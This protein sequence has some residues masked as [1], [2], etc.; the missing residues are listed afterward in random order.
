M[1]EK[2]IR[3]WAGRAQLIGDTISAL[4]VARHFKKSFPDSHLIWPIAKKCSQAAPL[5]INCEWIDEIYVTDGLDGPQSERDI[6]KRHSCDIGINENPQHPFGEQWFNERCIYE[7]TWLMAGRSKAIWDRLTEEEKTPK[8][9]KWFNLPD[10][11][12]QNKTIGL[13]CQAGYAQGDTSKR[14][15]SKKYWEQ[16][17]LRLVKE[18]YNIL[19][20][21]SEKDWNYDY[22]NLSPTIFK[23]LNNLSFFDQIKYSLTTDLT[24]GTDSGS[25]LVLAAYEHPQIS[26]LR[27]Y[28][29][30]GHIQ[31]PM[32][33]GPRNKNN[34]SLASLTESHDSID[35][36]LIF[37]KIYEFTK[38]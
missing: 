34:F 37:N 23:R 24:I 13:W 33:F 29:E 18:G 16:V 31:N 21:G 30:D 27:M 38:R 1:S 5:Y 19:Q 6:K 2:H 35:Q 15:P 3:I 32:A 20:F 22:L 9:E 36:G 17:I 28:Q 14:N 11:I 7:E 8:L 25:T 4:H 10:K 12:F 26:L